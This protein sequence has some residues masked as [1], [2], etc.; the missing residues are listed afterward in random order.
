M[1][2]ANAK[3]CNKLASVI[4]KVFQK[5]LV[6]KVN[7]SKSMMLQMQVARKT[8]LCIADLYNPGSQLIN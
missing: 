5:E 8:T 2:Y 1:T 3:S 6:N 4:S 7:G